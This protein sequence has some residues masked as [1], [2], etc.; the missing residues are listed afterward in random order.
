MPIRLSPQ[1][2]YALKYARPRGNGRVYDKEFALELLNGM[3]AR[4]SGDG[5]GW[6]GVGKLQLKLTCA[7]PL[8][9]KCGFR[10]I[11]NTKIGPS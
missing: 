1:G 9:L 6:S 10:S 7:A 8:T 4:K 11:V 3:I 5:L 2:S